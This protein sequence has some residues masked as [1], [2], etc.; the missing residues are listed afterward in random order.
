MAIVTASILKQ[1]FEESVAVKKYQIHED[2]LGWTGFLVDADAAAVTQ[3]LLSAGQANARSDQ[4]IVMEAWENSQT[5]VTSNRRDFVR[6]IQKFQSRENGPDCRDLSGLVV[7]PNL[8]LLRQKG[9][10]GVRHGVSVPKLGRLGWNGAAFLN[11]YLRVNAGQHGSPEVRRFERC[12]FCERYYPIP[13]P[14]NRWYR[15]LPIIGE[16]SNTAL[17]DEDLAHR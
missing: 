14:W 1:T 5:I 7:I 13:E 2:E 3:Y 9:L 8:H 4:E 16:R 15:S 11:L 10:D 12:S 6:Y 17:G